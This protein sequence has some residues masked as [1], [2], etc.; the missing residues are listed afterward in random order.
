[1]SSSTSVVKWSRRR[2]PSRCCV[3]DRAESDVRTESS[4]WGCWPS[5]A[6]WAC[7][8]QDHQDCVPGPTGDGSAGESKDRT[9]ADLRSDMLPV[10]VLL[11]QASRRSG[12]KVALGPAERP[13]LLGVVGLVVLGC[14]QPPGGSTASTATVRPGQEGV[15]LVRRTVSSRRS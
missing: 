1:V 8:R 14:R 10:D 6:R 13:D 15:R 5:A 7:R 12:P 2:K 11:L 9:R 4:Y 3:G